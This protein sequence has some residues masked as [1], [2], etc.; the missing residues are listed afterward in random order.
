MQI[1][2]GGG[3]GYLAQAGDENAHNF[4][5]PVVR[6]WVFLKTLDPFHDARQFLHGR[7]G[8]RCLRH[9]LELVCDG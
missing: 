7:S 6:Q 5:T 9:R 4:A 1:R 8:L 2:L 3:G